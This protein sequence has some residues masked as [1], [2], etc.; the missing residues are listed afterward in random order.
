VAAVRRFKEL[1]RLNPDL[2]TRSAITLL[3]PTKQEYHCIRRFDIVEFANK[4]F[5]IMKPSDSKD[6]TTVSPP[7]TTDF[8]P[9]LASF[10]EVFNIIARSHK[11]AGHVA[12]ENT[13]RWVRKFRANISRKVCALYV[14]MCPICLSRV[15]IP[16]RP[17]GNFHLKLLYHCMIASILIH[18]FF[19]LRYRISCHIIRYI[20]CQR[21]G[22]SH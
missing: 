11:E 18:T 8:C 9:L 14:S 7:G 6:V 10:D 21:S 1:R 15:K 22:R 3:R 20:Q 4:T 16:K 17:R 13:W 12:S 5:L 19:L 2:S